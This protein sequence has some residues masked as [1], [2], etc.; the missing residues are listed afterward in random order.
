[1][2]G[3][4][5]V[6]IGLIMTTVVTY[7]SMLVMSEGAASGVFKGVFRASSSNLSR[8]FDTD[9]TPA[10]WAFQVWNI[11]YLWQYLWLGYVLSRLF[12]RNEHGWVYMQPDILPNSFFLVW[13]LN[14]LLNIERLFLW[15]GMHLLPTLLL[16]MLVT[17][18]SYTALII[19][20]RALYPYTD[21]LQKHSYGDLLLIRLLVQ[22]GI[23]L[24]ATWNTIATL[25]DFTV[26][27]V[28][29]GGMDNET[30]TIISLCILFFGLIGWFYLENFVLDKYVR[31]DLTIYPG[32]LLALAGILKK[33][34]MSYSPNSISILVVL[35]LVMTGGLGA[36]RLIV[37]IDRNRKESPN[38]PPPLAMWTI[39]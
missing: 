11:V 3:H 20:H 1:M 24:Y 13:V 8:Q 15:D 29:I 27:L 17:S 32:V 5:L 19:S 22:N 9:F 28:Y 31:Y 23:A 7:T 37:V 30:A 2:P 39:S 10:P 18:T 34:P 6:K 38:E 14:N 4:D 12:R 25:L 33:K 16:M 35:L 36:I 21:W 26:V